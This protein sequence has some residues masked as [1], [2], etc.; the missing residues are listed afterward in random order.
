MPFIYPKLECL[1]QFIFNLEVTADMS[2]WYS[3]F[4]IKRSKVKVTG[5][6]NVKNVLALIFVVDGSIYVKPKPACFPVCLGCVIRHSCIGLLV[7]APGAVGC[8]HLPAP[9]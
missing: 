3:N 1:K 7:E 6:G 2:K 4:E 8:I 9:L 5:N